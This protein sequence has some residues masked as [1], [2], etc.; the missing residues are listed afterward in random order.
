MAAASVGVTIPARMVPSVEQMRSA[1][2]TIPTKN[3]RT[4]WPKDV[5]RSSLGTAGP[6]AGLM[7]LR[8][9]VYRMYRPAS[10][11]P[12]PNAAA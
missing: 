9:R 5:A 2:G 1:S 7:K 4:I 6:S 11:K 3:S 8:V 10:M 12:G